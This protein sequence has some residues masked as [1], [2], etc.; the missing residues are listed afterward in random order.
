MH[1]GWFNSIPGLYPLDSSSISLGEKKKTTNIAWGVKS[2]P[3]ENHWSRLTESCNGI[4]SHLPQGEPFMQNAF[5]CLDDAKLGS[6]E[7]T[8]LTM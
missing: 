4:G 2:A 1:Y 8:D 5:V 7:L 6:F 3:V